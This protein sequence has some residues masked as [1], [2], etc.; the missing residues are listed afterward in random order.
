MAPS[1]KP[2]RIVHS[3]YTRNS[4]T[5]DP[6]NYVT[7]D[8]THWRPAHSHETSGQLTMPTEPRDVYRGYVW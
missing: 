3:Y 4:G 6:P 8:G 1:P 7:E 5:G 2:L